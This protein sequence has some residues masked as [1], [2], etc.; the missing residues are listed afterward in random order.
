MSAS[1]GLTSRG[2]VISSDLH[3][4]IPLENLHSKEDAVKRVLHE[5]SKQVSNGVF[6]S[7]WSEAEPSS[8][9]SSGV[10]ESLGFPMVPPL[11]L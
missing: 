3:Q 1:T 4:F 8:L 10:A 11:S 9:C 5:N 6:L 2:K 7:G